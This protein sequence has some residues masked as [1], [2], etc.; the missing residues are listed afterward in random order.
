MRAFVQEWSP[1]IAALL[2]VLSIVYNGISIR[3]HTGGVQERL[4]TLE[5]DIESIHTAIA[6]EQGLV[7]LLKGLDERVN[8]RLQNLVVQQDKSLERH[9]QDVLNTQNA[10]QVLK[11]NV[12][13]ILSVTQR[14]EYI[15]EILLDV[16][17]RI[18]EI[19]RQQNRA[20]R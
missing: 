8:E 18:E 9:E 13:A 1:L 16:Q 11:S 10:L 3:T 12:D 4:A 6:G 19:R 15:E 17:G 20:N 7:V 14:M 2:V 5:K